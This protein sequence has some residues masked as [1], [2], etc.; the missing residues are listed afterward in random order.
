MAP[1]ALDIE[2]KS[3]ADSGSSPSKASLFKYTATEKLKLAQR[4]AEGDFR[5]DVVTVPNETIMQ[6]TTR[7]KPMPRSPAHACRPLSMPPLAMTSMMKT[8]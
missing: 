6:V 4:R 3:H 2:T 5:S 1:S 7:L 8:G